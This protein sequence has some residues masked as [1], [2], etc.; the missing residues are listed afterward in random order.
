MTNHSRFAFK[1]LKYMHM[2][3]AIHMINFNRHDAK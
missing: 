1:L 3:Y 2:A